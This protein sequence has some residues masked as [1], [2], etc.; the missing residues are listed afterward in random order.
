MYEMVPPARIRAPRRWVPVT[1]FIGLSAACCGCGVGVS[2][3]ARPPS[4]RTCVLVVPEQYDDDAVGGQISTAKW[5]I[6]D[7]EV[8]DGGGGA[9]RRPETRPLS[10]AM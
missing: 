8:G 2:Q 3:F 10:G 9:D 1:S 6:R 7:D 4:G 5:F